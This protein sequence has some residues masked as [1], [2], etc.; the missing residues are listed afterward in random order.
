MSKCGRKTEVYSRITGYYRPIQNWN[1]GKVEEF[2]NR[3]E[4]ELS[5]S[6]LT[7]KVAGVVG[8]KEEMETPA[9]QSAEILLFATKTCPDCKMAK[10]LLDNANIKYTVVDAEENIEK[11]KAFNIRKAPTLIVPKVEGGYDVFENASNIK[12]YIEGLN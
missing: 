12:G 10:M 5:K 8:S 9:P 2:Q 1:D 11:S 7:N 3:K 6:K 4:Y